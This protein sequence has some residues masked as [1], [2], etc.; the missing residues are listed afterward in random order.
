MPD[1]E[2]HCPCG[3][4]S[5]IYA[6]P[7]HPIPLFCNIKCSRLFYAGKG[8]KKKY[9][10]TPEMD[11]EIGEVYQKAVYMPAFH[12]TAPVK[13]MAQRFKIP[14]WKISSRAAEL[15]V[16]NIRKKEANWS[17]DELKLLA[18]QAHKHPEVIQ[19][20][21]K[22]AG[23]HRS[24][25]GIVLKR[26]RMHLLQ[27]LEFET[28]CSL[29]G[30]LG[31]DEQGVI[32]YIRK[33]MLKAKR[34]GTKRT[35]RQGGDQYLIRPSNIRKFIIENVSFLDFRKIDKFWLV[36]LL[37]GGETGLGPMKDSKEYGVGSK[38]K[39]TLDTRAPEAER[40]MKVDETKVEP[41]PYDYDGAQVDPEVLEVFEEP[42]LL[43]G[44]ARE[45]Q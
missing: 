45:V 17:E 37:A 41:L 34:R 1:Y 26:C 27:G 9:F 20:R 25:Q 36:E 44:Q 3:K 7:S 6:A 38:Q 24:V 23:Y 43:S 14:R 33:G 42:A 39:D 31:I 4:T 13:R 16:R 35:W 12:K 30:C 19:R 10:F 18:R 28:A 22:K 2:V 8:R 15:G 5:M 40:R 11:A 32:R 29:A 21:L